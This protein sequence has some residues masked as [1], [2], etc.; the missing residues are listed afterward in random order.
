MTSS[1]TWPTRMFSWE[2]QQVL[3]WAGKPTA[4]IGLLSSAFVTV[5]IVRDRKALREKVFRRLFLCVSL[6]HIAMVLL[7]LLATLPIPRDLS[8]EYYGAM[9]N[10]AS[11]TVAGVLFHWVFVL[12]M[13]YNGVIG[14]YYYIVFEWNWSDARIRN[15]IEKYMHGLALFYP[16]VG[17]VSGLAANMY[18][19]N[20]MMMQCWVTPEVP[21]RI[22]FI[23]LAGL[24][25]FNLAT[26][27]KMGSVTKIALT[28][29]WQERKNTRR[30]EQ[31]V[32]DSNLASSSNNLS[33]HYLSQRNSINSQRFSILNRPTSR[34]PSSSLAKEICLQA[35]LF[36]IGCCLPYIL[37]IVIKCFD[38]FW[39]PKFA[40][41]TASEGTDG[42]I[43]IMCVIYQVLFPI[44]GII[45]LV[46]FTRPYYTKRLKTNPDEI[47]RRRLYAS[48]IMALNNG[49]EKQSKST[50]K[51]TSKYIVSISNAAAYSN[52]S[53]VR[54]DQT[55]V[56]ALQ[57]EIPGTHDQ[58]LPVELGDSCRHTGSKDDPQPEVSTTGDSTQQDP[59]QHGENEDQG[60]SGLIE[61]IEGNVDD[62]QQDDVDF[63]KLGS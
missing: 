49:R 4:V 44:Q 37:S 51:S 42:F 55:S 6:G 3:V 38:M 31:S 45:N 22:V 53:N 34:S 17:A 1:S 54:S 39:A 25:E 26:M 28:F 10:D 14:L 20:P 61:D 13:V 2:E 5:A 16:T 32:R 9:G 58:D 21:Y 30:F 48:L 40:N 60:G 62:E 27:V 63:A 35:C 12:T 36:L 52:R 24:L 41:A 7:W 57:S 46:I 47:T 56:D 19:P 43:F 59:H 11:C 15:S 33:V 29:V 18:G 50:S 8:A 23:L